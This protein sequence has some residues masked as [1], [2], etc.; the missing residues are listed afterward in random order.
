MAD[1]YKVTR[2]YTSRVGGLPESGGE[3]RRSLIGARN[4]AH[5]Y[6]HRYPGV[7]QA[8]IYATDDAPRRGHQPTWKLIDTITAGGGLSYCETATA[9]P[10]STWHIRLLTAAGKK[11]NG[12]AD[13]PALCGREVAWDLPGDVTN[14]PDIVCP[15]C[16]AQVGFGA[17]S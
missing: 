8:R 15:S 16:Y 14:D 2:V 7:P 6:V 10:R 1:R 5:R 9:G 11:M 4:L 12:G 17:P 13:T 3:I